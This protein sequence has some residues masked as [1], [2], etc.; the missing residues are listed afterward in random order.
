MSRWCICIVVD[1]SI[2]VDLLLILLLR[3]LTLMVASVKL[4]LGVLVTVGSTFKVLPT[5]WT[6]YMVSVDRGLIS[7]CLL[8]LLLLNKACN[9]P[10]WELLS[11]DT[12]VSIT[13]CALRLF[14]AG[15]FADGFILHICRLLHLIVIIGRR[16]VRD[17]ALLVGRSYS[18][19]AWLR[20]VGFCSLNVV[21]DL[22]LLYLLMEEVLLLHSFVSGK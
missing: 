6:S 10:M 15:Y 4:L 18:N 9:V 21:Y 19:V 5:G 2:T 22:L 17:C 20:D 1:L 12:H 13:M 7:T 3:G 8:T 16:Q 11:N 14:E